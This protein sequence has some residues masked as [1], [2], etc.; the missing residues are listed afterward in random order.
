MSNLVSPIDDSL[1]KR[2]TSDAVPSE[3]PPATS[4]EQKS[5]AESARS[6][7]IGLWALALGFGGF[8]MWAA[9]APLDEGVPSPGV[10]S[11]DTKRKPVQHQTGGIVKEVLVREGVEVKE[12]QLLVRLDDAVSRSNFESVRQRYLGL[13]AMQ[14]RLQAEQMNLPTVK[15]HP[16][17]IAASKDPLIQQQMQTQLQLFESRR[18][19]LQADVQALQESVRG[20]E[21]SLQAYQSMLSGRKGQQALLTEELENTRG[22]VAEGYAPRNRQLELERMVAD[23]NLAMTDLRGNIDRANH[24]IAEIGQRVILRQKEYRKEVE[25]QLSDVSREVQ[26]DDVKFR[27]V[28]EEL[29]RTEI[30]APVA[31]QVMSLAVQTPG[32]VVQ[33]G[34]KLMD[35]V[36]ENE[37]LLLEA[38]VPPQFIDRVHD[39]LVVDIRFSAF[40]HSPQLVVAGKVVSVSS[41]LF[42]DP[43]SKSSY[44]LARINVTADGLKTLGQRQM[45]PGMPA[46]VV[47]KTGERSLLTYLLHPL[48]KRMAASLKEE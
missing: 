13:R 17:L 31:G 29:A 14:G 40:A 1:V 25:T 6:T 44:Y 46:E 30:K 37:A 43:E 41:D 27:A 32:S 9:Y 47:F 24:A 20:Q 34:Q 8:L 15:F 5:S 11:I 39:G 18:A 33:A 12:G 36:P 21:S 16:D 38:H 3:A 35:I 2:Q 26:S 4:A 42:V 23:S 22:L 45:Q 19:A 7:R 48:T 28:S 10:V